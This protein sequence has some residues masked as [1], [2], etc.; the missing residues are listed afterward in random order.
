MRCHERLGHE[1]RICRGGRP[2]AILDEQQ[3]GT[4]KRSGGVLDEVVACRSEGVI[5]IALG[6]DRGFVDGNTLPQ[7]RDEGVLGREGEEAA[8]TVRKEAG[9]GLAGLGEVEL[10]LYGA[11]L[12]IE[13]GELLPQDQQ[14]FHQEKIGV[15]RPALLLNVS[16]P[17]LE[18]PGHASHA[19]QSNVLE[20]ARFDHTKYLGQ[21]SQDAPHWGE[22]RLVHAELR[23]NGVVVLV[24]GT[25]SRGTGRGR[26]LRRHSATS[27]RPLSGQRGHFRRL[28]PQE[29]AG[30][31]QVLR[32][33]LESHH[34][35]V[36]LRVRA[37]DEP[38]LRVD[39]DGPD[40][41]RGRGRRWAGV[42]QTPLLPQYR[43]HLAQSVEVMH[44]HEAAPDGAVEGR[45]EVG[46]Q[47]LE[48]DVPEGRVGREVDVLGSSA[49]ATGGGRGSFARKF[50]PRRSAGGGGFHCHLIFF[51]PRLPFGFVG[52]ILALLAAL[53]FRLLFVPEEVQVQGRL[54]RAQP[55]E[56]N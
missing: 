11:K 33:G 42:G 52:A 43:H 5:K 4:A 35:L 44:G 7:K 19:L 2:L 10:A 53:P 21:Y 32:P 41:P 9:N 20:N 34:L 1:S 17:I 24:A 30:V 37:E 47:G 29:L 48:R 22:P 31:I 25:R 28:S 56:E 50:D 40:G 46:Q 16:A 49:G 38:L 27:L 36:K 51:V 26:G 45:A 8:V 12:D 14:V 3:G 39:D 13:G 23:L 15:N 18:T 6:I 54:Y 55:D